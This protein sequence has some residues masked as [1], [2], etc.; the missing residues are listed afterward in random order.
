MALTID[1]RERKLL[2]VC[3]TPHSVQ[4]LQVGDFS[5]D[6][7]DPSKNWVGERKTGADLAASI[8]D[9]RWHEQQSR[10]FATGMRVIFVVEGD[11]EGLGVPYAS[12]LGAV[13]NAQ[14]RKGCHLYRT[15]D[16]WETARLLELL[17]PKMAFWSSGAPPSGLQPATTSKRKREADPDTC[18]IRMLMS[19]PSISAKV[20]KTLVDRFKSLP[21]L[22]EA[23]AATSFPRV[24][25]DE[26]TVLGKARLKKLRLHL[27]ERR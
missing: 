19:I 23:L 12:L 8:K 7:A 25:L 5:C 21:Q 13:V 2:E 24:Q 14:M 27:I 9:G 1:S 10:L 4:Y 16:V 17:V 22:Q 11:L 18:M 20:A 15:V 3:G 26:R 6:Y